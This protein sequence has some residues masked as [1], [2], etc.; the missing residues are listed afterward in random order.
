MTLHVD[1]LVATFDYYMYL[2]TETKDEYKV[3]GELQQNNHQSD[4]PEGASIQ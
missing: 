4:K 3:G 2:E 1:V